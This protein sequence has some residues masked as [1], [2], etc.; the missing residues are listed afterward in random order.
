MN[1]WFI[2]CLLLPSIIFTQNS[3]WVYRNPYPQ[4]DFYG[5]KFLDQN[6]GYLIGEGG[7]FLKSTSGS[8]NWINIPT[9]TTRDLFAMNFFDINTGYIAGDGGLI[10]YTSNGGTNWVSVVTNNGYAFRS[11]TF[12]NQNTGYAA[13]DHGELYKTTSGITGWQRINLN[14]TSLNLNEVYFLIENKGFVCADSGKIYRTTNSGLNWTTINVGVNYQN[15]K[16]IEFIDSLNGFIGMAAAATGS[17]SNLYKTTDGG[18]SWQNIFLQMVARDFHDIKF[19]NNN[20]GFACSDN[21]PVL[22]TTNSGNMW[23]P[24]GLPPSTLMKSISKLDTSVI[25]CG[26]NGWISK[27]GPSGVIDVVGGSKK[28]FIS[29]SFINENS[30]ICIGDYQV[31]RTVNSGFNWG[32]QMI[33]NYGWFEG[34]THLIK[35]LSFPS[36]NLYLVNHTYIPTW[37]PEEDILRSTDGGVTWNYCFGS[38]G[39]FGGLDEKEGVT[40][41]THT[42]SVL[43][44]TGGTFSNLYSVTGSMLG[45][46]SFFNA[47]T[48]CVISNNNS[49]SNGLLKTTNG[50]I[51]WLFIPNSGNKY[52]FNLEFL[53]SGTGYATGI[54]SGYFIR[55][56]NYGSSWQVL[57][58]GLNGN[59]RDMKFKDDFNGW[60]LNYLASPV[61]SNRLY[62][63]KNGGLNFYP[64][65]SLVEFNVKSF[66]FVNPNT[67]FVCGDSG[68]VLKTTNGGLTFVVT[69]IGSLP[70]TYSL[71][72]NYPNPFNPVTNIRFELPK[73]GFV[74]LTIYDING[75]EITKLVEQQMNAGSYITDWDASDYACGVYIYSIE[76]GDYRESKRMVLLK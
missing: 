58:T 46:V 75:R 70:N 55:T 76:A 14:S 35:S 74:E 20:T 26:T 11:I 19:I 10:L 61:M 22:I 7:T 34:D 47:N 62:F 45:D 38:L 5:V 12:I 52:L 67:G 60:L 40:Y 41:L 15:V 39:Y 4:T 50:G 68:K 71:K 72:Q 54:D 33:G 28:D 3:D 13:G 59:N 25:I 9:Y 69:G 63:T 53:P 56:T 18:S 73:S 16:C 43:K 21:G 36:G 57:N 51:N 44:S 32:I 8:N 29:I 2:L 64:V 23:R 65:T 48:G 42:S 1:C 6:T 27:A 30:G 66:S 24:Y 31:I 37:Y 49:G 17:N